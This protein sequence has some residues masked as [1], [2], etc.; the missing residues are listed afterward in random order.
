MRVSSKLFSN[1]LRSRVDSDFPWVAP[2]NTATISASTSSEETHEICRSWISQCKSEH[3]LCGQWGKSRSNWNPTQVLDVSDPNGQLKIRLF[4]PRDDSEPISYTTLNHRWGKRKEITLLTSNVEKFKEDIPMG[5]LVKTFQDA[6]LITRR[7]SIS[8]LWIDSLCIIQD[9][10]DQWRSESARMGDVYKYGYCNIAATGA[11]DELEGRYFDRDPFVVKPLL[12]EA[13]W[14]WHEKF[15]VPQR[16]CVLGCSKNEFCHL[17]RYTLDRVKFFWECCSEH[18]SETWPVGPRKF[19]DSTALKVRHAKLNDDILKTEL[20]L[21]ATKLIPTALNYWA[22]IVQLYSGTQLIVE[23]DRL[24]ALSGIAQSVQEAIEAEYLAGLWKHKLVY[25]LLW[26]LCRHEKRARSVGYVAPTWSWASLVGKVEDVVLMSL[27]EKPHTVWVTFLEAQTNA[28][29][30]SAWSSL[31]QL[32][33]GSR[34]T[35]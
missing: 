13:A 35:G 21:R 3:K 5:D 30:R 17:G 11:N 12:L 6:I 9:S 29:S 28:D 34:P 22:V 20:S 23:R 19:T 8:Y 15:W 14:R 26:K 7:L 32:H 2:Y 33:Q 4:Q 31:A 18:A 1:E 25:Q 16:Y 27:I 24:I 10:I